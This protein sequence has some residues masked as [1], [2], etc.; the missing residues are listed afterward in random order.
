MESESYWT[1][2]PMTRGI[3][4]HFAWNEHILSHNELRYINGTTKY[5]MFFKYD[6]ASQSNRC[7]VQ[8]SYR[9]GKLIHKEVQRLSSPK[10]NGLE[11]YH[12]RPSYE[13]YIVSRRVP[14]LATDS[15][16]ATSLIVVFRAVDE[17]LASLW[18]STL[19]LYFQM[20]VGV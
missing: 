10:Q 5:S 3:K 19:G 12:G 6:G 13:N 16:L 1:L 20:T 8:T 9:S 2:L 18:W 11:S 17:P 4:Q 14:G 15:P 7:K